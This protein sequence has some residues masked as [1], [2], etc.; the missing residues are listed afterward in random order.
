MTKKERIAEAM[1]KQNAA[2][3]A[4]HSEAWWTDDIGR[5]ERQLTITQRRRNDN[6]WIG[7]NE[8]GAS[9]VFFAS[10]EDDH[11]TE[12][13]LGTDEE[14]VEHDSIQAS[15]NALER[16]RQSPQMEGSGG[17]GGQDMAAAP[18][19]QGP[20]GIADNDRGQGLCSSLLGHTVAAK[21]RIRRKASPAPL[22]DRR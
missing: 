9:S 6:D 15:F 3:L 12:A 20:P 1:R 13:F 17:S 18:T 11:A 21:K 2:A 22:P 10:M 8:A 14:G 7:V 5:A 4:A 16:S 19:T